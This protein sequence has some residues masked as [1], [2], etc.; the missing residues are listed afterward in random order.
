MKLSPLIS[1]PEARLALL[2]AAALGAIG[3]HKVEKAEAP[4]GDPKVAGEKITFPNDSSQL[5]TLTVE[6]AKKCADS[7]IRLNGRLVWNDNVTVRV[8]SPFA[9]RVTGIDAEVGA[10]VRRDTVLARIISPDFGQAQADARKALTD[11]KLAERNAA[12][13]QELAQHGAAATKDVA[14]AEADLA[15]AQAESQRARTR[16]AIY[17][18]NMDAI[19]NGYLLKTPIDGVVVERNLNPGQEVRPD[20]MLASADRLAAPLFVVTDP[21]KLWVQLDVS[22][23]DLPRLRAGQGLTVRVPSVDRAF[24]AIVEIISDSLDPV[25]RTVKVR[26]AIDNAE[27]LLKAEML[28]TVEVPAT[29]DQAMDVPAKS[30]FFKAEHHYVYCEEN[31]GTFSRREVSIGLSHDGKIQ[32]VAGLAESD[33]VVADGAILLEQ[34]RE[35]GEGG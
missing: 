24:P 26:A 5:A 31:R 9:G 22:E 18:G 3:C 13:L 23:T 4:G 2:A 8:F 6:P 25:T 12:R 15:R 27:K 21:R 29:G 1:S 17:G 20:Q 19:D 16:L 34:I 14:A 10:T 11:L 32:V 7:K 30:V 33:K 28:V 35:G